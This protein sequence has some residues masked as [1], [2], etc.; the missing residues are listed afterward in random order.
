RHD[1]ELAGK[2]VAVVGT[3]ASA[4]QFVPQIAPKVDKL[5]VFQRTP[6]WIVPKA[7]RPIGERERWMLEHVPGAHW[8]RRTGLDW[9]LESRVL[10][11][12]FAPKVNQVAEGLV[13]R[14][15]KQSVADPELRA[16]LTPEYRLGC[17]RVLISNDYY[18]ALQRPNVELVT[19]G[20]AGIEASGIR[21]TDG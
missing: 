18:P 9:M 17:K 2:R 3:G 21:T 5:H 7:D 4:I 11:F 6:P 16:K 10:G 12:A 1:V 15:I 13:R 8:L 14:Y 19:D 20:I